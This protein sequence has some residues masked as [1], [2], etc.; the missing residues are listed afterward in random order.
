MR[1][2]VGGRGWECA[3][4]SHDNAVILLVTIIHGGEELV[5]R[6]MDNID[7]FDEGLFRVHRLWTRPRF[8]LQRLQKRARENCRGGARESWGRHGMF[9]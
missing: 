9:P 4:K 3:R 7:N 6:V 8:A 1:G 2:G 5:S